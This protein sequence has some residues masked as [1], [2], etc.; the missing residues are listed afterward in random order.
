MERTILASQNEEVDQLNAF[1]G[2]QFPCQEPEFVALSS[3]EA[4]TDGD[5]R[6]F[7]GVPVEILNSHNPSGVPPHKLIL[8]KGM[9][10]MLRSSMNGYK[11][12]ANGTSLVCRGFT[13]RVIDAEVTTGSEQY[14][15]QRIVIPRISLYS[16]DDGMQMPFKPKRRTISSAPGICNDHQQGAGADLEGR[17]SASSSTSVLPW[18][19][20]CGYIRGW[21][22]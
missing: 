15:S 19:L 21:S 2:S 22:S 14:V 8:K 12:Q 18:T 16:S 6:E 5:A 10:I 3:D 1:I 7:G 13:R 20:S 11:G 9:P 4:E 17:G